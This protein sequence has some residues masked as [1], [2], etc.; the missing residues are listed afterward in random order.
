MK[1]TRSD[2]VRIMERSACLY[3]ARD[4]LVG[5]YREEGLV[6]EWGAAD[7]QQVFNNVFKM[8][9]INQSLLNQYMVGY[10]LM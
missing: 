10:F 8:V 9:W 6:W 1:Q 4:L 5:L 2:A 3:G 7:R